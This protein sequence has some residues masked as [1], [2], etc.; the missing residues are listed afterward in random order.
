MR[1][2]LFIGLFA[3]AFPQSSNAQAFGVRMGDSVANYAG[4]PGSGKGQ[5]KIKVPQPNSEFESYLALTTPETGICAVT[6]LGRDHKDAYGS[7]IR[8]S[9]NKL[10]SVLT[11]RYGD[12]EEYDF[13]KFKSIWNKPNEFNWGIYKQERTLAAFWKGG[14]SPQNENI[15]SVGMIVKSVNPDSAYIS[16]RY[17]FRNID[18][19]M[20]TKNKTDNAGL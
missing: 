7:E 6:G 4:T 13:L 17:E 11:E 12:V 18:R 2:I 10:K 19:C 16:L 14:T 15:E 9:Y 1:T 3:L 20:E 5:Y 8:A